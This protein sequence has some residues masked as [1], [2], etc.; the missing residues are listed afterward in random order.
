MSVSMEA[1]RAVTGEGENGSVNQPK[2]IDFVLVGALFFE[3]RGWGREEKEKKKKKE[4]ENG[5]CWRLKNDYSEGCDE[6]LLNMFV[7]VVICPDHKVPLPTTLG[8]GKVIPD[9]SESGLCSE[10]PNPRIEPQTHIS[11]SDPHSTCHLTAH[12]P[13]PCTHQLQALPTY[14]YCST[15]HHPHTLAEPAPAGAGNNHPPVPCAG[16]GPTWHQSIGP[17]APASLSLVTPRV[18]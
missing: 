12:R 4:V 14:Y 2:S 3:A 7:D 15:S 8:N 10:H 11:L 18:P 1:N 6:V 16:L 17:V 9:C 5:D 13:C